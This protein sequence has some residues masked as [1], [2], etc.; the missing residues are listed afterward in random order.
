MEA[1]LGDH[2]GAFRCE[3]K[4]RKLLSN[5]FDQE[6]DRFGIVDR[7]ASPGLRERERLE[8]AVYAG[9]SKI[10][11][12]VNLPRLRHT[13]ERYVDHVAFT[14]RD[15]WELMVAVSLSTW[16]EQTPA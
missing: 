8:H 9:S 16:L 15:V 10:A 14:E 2:T 4:V 12:Y 5:P 3:F 6:L 11:E 7:V 13:Y 1:D